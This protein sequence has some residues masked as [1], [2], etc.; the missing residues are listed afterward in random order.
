MLL[1]PGTRLGPYEILSPLGAG[2]MGEVYR[3]KD[4]R[5]GRD[6]AVKVL[7]THLSDQPEVRARFEREAKT[8]SS[9][10]HPNI[11]ALYDVGKEGDIDYLVLELI[12]GDTLD[13]RLARGPLPAPEAL[14]LGAQIADALDRAHRAGVVHRDLKPGNVMLT[15]GGAKLMDFGLARAT[16]LGGAGGG[17]SSVTLAQ[18]PTIG[19]ALTAEG[20]ILGTFQ[21]MAPEQLEG[22]ETDA[23]TDV[24]ALGCVLYEMAAGRRA[25]DATSQAS[26]IGAIMAAEPP[27]LTNAQPLA[28][29]AFDRVVRTCLAKDP[30][31]RWQT[32]RDVRREL[33]WLREAGPVGA[34]AVAPLPRRRA[35]RM[36]ALAVAALALVAMGAGLMWMLGS[37]FGVPSIARPSLD[38]GPADELDSSGTA[39]SVPG[40][41]QIEPLTRGGV[42]TALT[43]TACCFL[44]TEFAPNDSVRDS[45]SPFP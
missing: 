36:A 7:P 1:T 20:T 2:G 13:A 24:F 37:T 34:A 31:E 41:V 3:A 8:V 45:P 38:V 9:L 11:C 19:R 10:N 26:L 40:A 12:E 42:R 29:P 30:E 17:S 39:V 15:R 4:T 44:F 21:Y 28:P 43:M 32:A 18:S 6:V 25:F 22:R 16:G 27:P 33:Q 35:P 14:R 5:L 23:R